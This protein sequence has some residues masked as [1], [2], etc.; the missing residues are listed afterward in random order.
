MAGTPTWPT[1]MVTRPTPCCETND[2]SVVTPQSCTQPHG[3]DS[4]NEADPPS[5]SS[6]GSD[7]HQDKKTRIREKERRGEYKENLRRRRGDKQCQD[8]E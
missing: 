3:W 2:D 7:S 4:G 5:A 8:E 1:P 6:Q